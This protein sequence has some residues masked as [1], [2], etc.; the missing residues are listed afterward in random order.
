MKLL[1]RG[2]FLIN[3]VDKVGAGH[4]MRRRKLFLPV[5]FLP[6]Y[7]PSSLPLFITLEHYKVPF[8]LTML[9]SLSGW[10]LRN[11]FVSS[12]MR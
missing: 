9:P 3:I 12:G 2:H 10:N 8:V 4:S 11:A 1:F 7:L 5:N 6:S